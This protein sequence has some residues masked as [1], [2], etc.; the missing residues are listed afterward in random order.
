MFYKQTPKNAGLMKRKVDKGVLRFVGDNIYTDDCTTPIKEL[1]NENAVELA[2]LLS[3]SGR[4]AYASGLTGRPHRGEL[5]LVGS[6][7][8]Q[9]E[10]ADIRIT[11]Y[12]ASTEELNSIEL[13]TGAHLMV[14]PSFLRAI[15]ENLSHEVNPTRVDVSKAKQELEAFYSRATENERLISDSKI[16]AICQRIS[17]KTQEVIEDF[18][19]PLRAKEASK[20]DHNVLAIMENLKDEMLSQPPSFTAPLSLTEAAL[21]LESYF[22]NFIEGSC[23]SIEE[24]KFVVKNRVVLKRH[25]AANDV[26]KLSNAIDQNLQNPPA[27]RTAS[28]WKNWCKTTHGDFFA[29]HPDKNPGKFKRMKNYAGS[30]QFTLPVLV[31]ETLDRVFDISKKLPAGWARGCFLKAGFLMVHPFEDGNGRIGRLILNHCLTEVRERRLIVPTVL[32]EDYLLGM[33]ALSRGETNVYVRMMNKVKELT[34]TATV[35]VGLDDCIKVWGNLSAFVSSDDGKWGRPPDS[36]NTNV[37]SQSFGA[38]FRKV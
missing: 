4:L 37:L 33:F 24:A 15:V 9:W 12:S 7:A 3:F 19:K 23:L 29:H 20:V 30:T 35:D 34:N 28:E 11:Q 1:V 16:R 38:A 18:L 17:P 2:S 31:E 5:I 22:S 6:K 14:K 21:F 13:V 32:R 26:L 10:A 8:R 27:W 25:G 36:Q